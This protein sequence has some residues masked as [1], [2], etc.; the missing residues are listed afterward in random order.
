MSLHP[1][2]NRLRSECVENHGPA[3]YISVIF[4]HSLDA[5]YAEPDEPRQHEQC[6][7]CVE[8]SLCWCARCAA[9]VSV[10]AA[11]GAI[12]KPAANAWRQAATASSKQR[13]DH[14]LALA[15]R[16]RGFKFRL[17]PRVPN[18]KKSYSAFAKCCALRAS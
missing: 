17:S 8:Y 13:L 6:R 9:S 10:W 14:G 15:L 3:A 16:L 11:R 4:M 1:P 2:N 7:Q 18:Q 5:R 12:E